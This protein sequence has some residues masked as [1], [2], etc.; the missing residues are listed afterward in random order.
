MTKNFS[1]LQ[2]SL[3]QRVLICR[4]ALEMACFAALP[5]MCLSAFG[6]SGSPLVLLV[7][8]TLFVTWP[9]WILAGIR[10]ALRGALFREFLKVEIDARERPGLKAG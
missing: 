9:I 1:E 6:A 5:W 4:F 7:A 3:W 8:V 10:L 2:L